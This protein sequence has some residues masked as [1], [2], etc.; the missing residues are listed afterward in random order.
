MTKII[1]LSN[2]IDLCIDERIC[3]AKKKP[4]NQRLQGSL[5]IVVT[6]LGFKPKTF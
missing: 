1:I 3:R 5:K 2:K 6:P 4:S